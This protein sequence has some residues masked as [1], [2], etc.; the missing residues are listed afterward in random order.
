VNLK[1]QG[2][3]LGR[4]LGKKRTQCNVDMLGA[5]DRYKV[6]DMQTG[7]KFDTTLIDII[8]NSVK[9]T[10]VFTSYVEV[11]DRAAEIIT[12]EGGFPLKVYGET[13]NELPQIVTQFDRD[14]RSNPLIATLQSLST[15]VPLIMANTVIFL[16]APYRDYIYDQ[17]CSR[18]DRLGQTE[19]V[20]IFDV[21]LDTGKE[22]NISSRSLDI[23]AWS[24]SMVDQMLGT[25]G[26]VA[27]EN[28][29][30]FADEIDGFAELNHIAQPD[31]GPE[32]KLV[33]L[34]SFSW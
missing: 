19:V 18:V 22:A 31:P 20:Q 32:V 17:A 28:L 8:E 13:N 12:G 4:I 3:A 27:L 29:D 2:E 11:V 26:S 25:A 24:K 10:V 5:W 33:A 14:V 7:E 34:E 30:T 23:M 1:V 21:Y 9:K 16:N 6:T 15:A